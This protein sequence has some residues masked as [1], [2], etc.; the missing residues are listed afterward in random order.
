MAEP[1][2]VPNPALGAEL[3]REGT[4]VPDERAAADAIAAYAKTIAPVDS[5]AFQASIRVSED[6]HDVAVYSDV[7]YAP[8]LE[9]GTSDTPTFATLRRAGEAV[10]N[11][12]T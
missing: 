7:A 12:G 3:E 8:Y 9:F 11:L 5:G 6:G 10:G 2:F 4:L 1:L